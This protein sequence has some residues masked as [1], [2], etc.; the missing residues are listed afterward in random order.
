[1]ATL[2]AI[3][4]ELLCNGWGWYLITGVDKSPFI[5]RINI[6]RLFD[7]ERVYFIECL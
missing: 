7:G 4:S 3:Y 6:W 1:M 5:P 2:K